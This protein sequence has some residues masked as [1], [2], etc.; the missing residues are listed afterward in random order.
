MYT[1]IIQCN[2]INCFMIT[3]DIDDCASDPCDPRATCMDQR[4]SYLCI[5]PEG[6]ENDGINLCTSELAK[7]RILGLPS[8]LHYALI[9]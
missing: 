2:I 9:L 1:Y 5:C 7:L 3:I 8:A 6:F 4:E